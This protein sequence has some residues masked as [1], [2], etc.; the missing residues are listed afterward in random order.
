M[1][2]LSTLIIAS[3]L[4]PIRALIT[5]AFGAFARRPIGVVLAA[6]ASAS[7]CETILTSAH[8]WQ[9]WVQGIIAGFIAC[10]LQA[11]ALHWAMKI[12]HRRGRIASAR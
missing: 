4:D 1:D 10:L 2:P 6:A 8:V 3:V 11:V 9:F 7:V 5:A 12:M